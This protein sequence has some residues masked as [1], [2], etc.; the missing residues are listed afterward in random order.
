MVKVIPSAEDVEGK[1]VVVLC[2]SSPQRC[3]SDL[4]ALSFNVY[5]LRGMN[6]LKTQ[7][8][9]KQSQQKLV[10]AEAIAQNALL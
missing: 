9:L 8:L 3:L 5:D 1:F 2:L 7:Q 4:V 10:H 6:L